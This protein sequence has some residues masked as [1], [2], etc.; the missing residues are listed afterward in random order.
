MKLKCGL[1]DIFREK[2]T[3]V[4]QFDNTEVCVV[5]VDGIFKAF[6]NSC[7]HQGIPLEDG[8]IKD[9]WIVCRM[10]GWLFDMDSGEC[11]VNPVCKLRTY[12][13]EI[14]NNEVFLLK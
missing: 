6:K 12:K 3:K 13:I 14:I 10:H 5:K 9:N 2:E 8:I 11:G 1:V 7:P 4:Y